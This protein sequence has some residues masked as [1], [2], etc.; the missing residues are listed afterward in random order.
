[1]QYSFTTT[2]GVDV[3]KNTL[4]VFCHADNKFAQFNN[5]PDGIKKLIKWVQQRADE[6][7]VVIEPTGGYERMLQHMVL[8]S[9]GLHLAKINARQIRQ[10]ARAKGRIA[11][12]DHIDARILA[13]YGMAFKPRILSLPPEYRQKLSALVK[14]RTQLNNNAS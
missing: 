6:S 3:S 12:T 8:T 7:L 10:F 11:K 9:E 2:I 1:M 14:R 4:D 5:T 13:E